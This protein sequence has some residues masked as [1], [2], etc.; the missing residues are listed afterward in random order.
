M[1]SG[2]QLGGFFVFECFDAFGNLKWRDEAPNMV[3]AAGLAHILDVVFSG[4]TVATT[5]HCGLGASSFTVASGDTMASHAGWTELTNYTGNRKEWVE[6]RTAASL[7]NAAS[8]ATFVF[9]TAGTVGGGVLTN[10]STGSDIMMAGAA[11]T[12]G[13]RAVVDTDTIN[14]TY[15]FSAADS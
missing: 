13:D 14:L 11:L 5:W 15:V 9:T 1:R 7:T 8:A 6:V 2:V 10:L 12:G 3:V 4:A